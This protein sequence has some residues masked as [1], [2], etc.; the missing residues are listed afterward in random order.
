[1]HKQLKQLHL[2]QKKN[3]KAKNGGKNNQE[4]VL[5]NMANQG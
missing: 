4:V 3:E 1:M 2:H 5:K